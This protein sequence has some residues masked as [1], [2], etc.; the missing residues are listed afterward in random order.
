MWPAS[1]IFGEALI[2]PACPGE[3]A[4]TFDDGPNPAWTP[5][6]L[7]ILARYEVRASFFMVGKYAQCEA[8]LV[9]KVAAAGHLIGCH[10]WSHPNLAVTGAGRVRDELTR[11][12][13][14]LAEITGQPIRYFRP[15]FGGRRPAVL[16]IV[17]ELGMTAVLWNA[18]TSDWSEPSEDAIFQSLCRKIDGLERRGR[19]ANIVLHDGSHAD[20]AAH[21]GPSVGT[22]DRL[23]GRYNGTHRFVTVDAW[24]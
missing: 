8:A 11:S 5:R 17:R 21:R 9:R 6:L 1:R 23:L 22:V 12:R 20:P 2:A 15:P 16:R 3:L 7:E 18:M 13:D 24:G 10:S 4:L 19:A 14:A